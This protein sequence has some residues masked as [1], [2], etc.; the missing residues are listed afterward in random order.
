MKIFHCDSC[1]QMVYF[2]N[3]QCVSC[4]SVLAYSPGDGCMVALQPAEGVWR[5][6]GTGMLYRL[7]ENYASHQV[8]NWA[9]R[10]EDANVFC[11]CCRL[12]RV[13]PD[14]SVPGNLEAWGRVEVAK[15]RLMYS[16]LLLGLPVV[17][18]LE[19]PAGGLAFEFLGDAPGGQTV[20]T[21]HDDGLVTLNIAEAD[22]AQREKRRLAL[23]EPYRTL[24]GHF[25]HEIGHYYWD[26]LIL[27]G[28]RLEDFRVLFGDERRD[29]NEALQ[30]HYSA[31]APA[32]WQ[33]SFITA[34]ATA[35]PW[36]DWAET[37]AHYLHMSDAIEVAASCG[38]SMRP[39]R[40][41]EPALETAPAAAQSGFE[42][43]MDAWFPL[44]YVVN[45]LNRGLG[46]PDGYPFVLSPSA[47]EKLRFVHDTIALARG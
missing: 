23:G 44:T 32:N 22:D 1:D 11:S 20:L 35:H 18:K 19:D 33:D 5:R 41:N 16:L 40:R 6:A 15:R 43:L 28:A 38:L 4:G 36:E 34:Y 29:Y 8:C 39:G 30:V 46:L 3:V 7:C 21:G 9:L 42:A 12:N 25:R 37:W 17:S 24:L 26:R 10:A 27:P 45:N 13:I 47:V 2:E 31:G 14:L